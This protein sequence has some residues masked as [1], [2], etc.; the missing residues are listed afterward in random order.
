MKNAYPNSNSQDPMPTSSR[1]KTSTTFWRNLFFCLTT[2]IFLEKIKAQTEPPADTSIFQKNEP[3]ATNRPPSDTSIFGKIEMHP[4]WQPK[5]YLVKPETYRQIISPYEG[6]IIDSTEIAADGSFHFSKQNLPAERTLFRL[7]IQRKNARF[8]N[9][10]EPLWAENF[11]LVSLPAT[12]PLEITGKAKRFSQTYFLKKSDGEN[13]L[14]QQIRNFRRPIFDSLAVDEQ[15]N[16]LLDPTSDAAVTK[17]LVSEKRMKVKMTSFLDTT[18]QFLPAFAAL[19]FLNPHSEYGSNSN[20]YEN[21]GHIWASIAP[22]NQQAWVAD[23]YKRVFYQKTYL[24]VGDQFPEKT[25]ETADGDSLKIEAVGGLR[26]LWFWTSWMKD[27]RRLQEEFLQPIFKK[28]GGRGLQII[29]I[30]ADDRLPAW[31]KAL[32]SQPVGWKNARLPGGRGDEFLFEVQVEDFPAI[33][34]LD[35]EGKI[36]ARN[37]SIA[38]LGKLLAQILR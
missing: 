12:E 20:F 24:L 7:S 32:E 25:L 36:L 17:V 22:E 38:D 31:K 15:G 30:S 19:Q 10:I 29:G 34:L 6:K 13:N 3:E 33:F 14:L 8:Q 26:L 4:D 5:L 2:L 9:K 11:A 18:R 23:F 1:S 28:Y 35:G 27:A 37:I 21:L 16:P